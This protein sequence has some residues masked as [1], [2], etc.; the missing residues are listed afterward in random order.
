MVKALHMHHL[1]FSML[2]ELGGCCTQ[3]GRTTVSFH[4]TTHWLVI[5]WS[6]WGFPWNSLGLQP[7]PGIGNIIWLLKMVSWDSVSP[8]G[9]LAGRATHGPAQLL[10]VSSGVALPQSLLPG[11]LLAT[12]MLSHVCHCHTHLF[13]LVWVDTKKLLLP[14]T[15][16][17]LLPGW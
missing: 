16:Q 2:N 12:D 7:S 17:W 15:W 10:W 8:G 4:E 6:V 3:Q 5:P 14:I 1:N 13:G 11:L 9:H